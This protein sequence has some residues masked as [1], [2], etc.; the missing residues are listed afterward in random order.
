MLEGLSQKFVQFDQ[1]A[2]FI[3]GG[4][5]LNSSFNLI[6]RALNAV[7][8]TTPASPYSRHM[9]KKPLSST[10]LEIIPV[11]GNLKAVSD[12]YK[13]KR[14]KQEKA[15]AGSMT[16]ENREKMIRDL[17]LR[18]FD[19]D[20]DVRREL[21]IALLEGSQEQLIRGCQILEECSEEGDRMS[22][23][24]LGEKLFNDYEN[25]E[26]KTSVQAKVLLQTVKQYLEKACEEA[27]S[28]ETES[29][30]EEEERYLTPQELPYAQALLVGVYLLEDNFS[31]AR[32]MIEK[33]LKMPDLDNKV[34]GKLYYLLGTLNEK[35]GNIK[36]ALVNYQI[37][38]NDE[39]VRAFIELG[40]LYR[41]EGKGQQAEKLLLQA[42][43]EGNLEE[44]IKAAEQLGK[45]Y[46]SSIGKQDE[47]AIP[48]LEMMGYH[49]DLDSMNWLSHYYL[50]R[51]D[52]HNALE[53]F[54]MA[55]QKGN[56]DAQDILATNP[57]LKTLSKGVDRDL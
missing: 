35:E 32:K 19:G 33:T 34:A 43:H 41:I 57:H 6:G 3:P 46:I 53:W 16:S 38:V 24:L 2:K 23:C 39:H 13:E 15:M 21:A 9:A 12:Y 52:Y 45:L 31:E 22:S 36:S 42:Y 56:K 4:S 11:I 29:V 50:D 37:A 49:G 55:A 17:E 44:R 7:K 18:A 8:K 51:R 10:M 27:P 5:A 40:R 28:E 20:F 14:M 25:L 1:A 30:F 26:D 47:K 48:Y 54:T